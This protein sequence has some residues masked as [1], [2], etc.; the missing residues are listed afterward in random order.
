MFEERELK[1]PSQRL[2][3]SALTFAEREEN[4]LD[5]QYVGYQILAGLLDLWSR[6]WRMA[7]NV[8]DLSG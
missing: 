8:V 6:I 1:T 4:E 3:A 7:K 5:L 2:G